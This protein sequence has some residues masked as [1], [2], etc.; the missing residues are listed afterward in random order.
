MDLADLEKLQAAVQWLLREGPFARAVERLRVEL[1][2][3]QGP[4]V[5][6]TVALDTIRVALPAPY[7]FT[8]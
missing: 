7:S 6:T 2:G 3:S 5:W 4:F 8:A 1:S